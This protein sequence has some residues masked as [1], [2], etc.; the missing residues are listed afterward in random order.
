MKSSTGRSEVFD[1]AGEGGASA[2]MAFLVCLL[3]C[4][5]SSVFMNYNSVSGIRGS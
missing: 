4:F 2:C 5:L 1:R 3:I